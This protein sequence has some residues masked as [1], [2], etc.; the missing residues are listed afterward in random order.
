[1]RSRT[2]IR[3][4]FCV[5]GSTVPGSPLLPQ[6][7]PTG[8]MGKATAVACALDAGRKVHTAVYGQPGTVLLAS[9]NP[10]LVGELDA[11]AVALSIY[12]PRYFANHPSASPHHNL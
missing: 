8:V 4:G 10:S 6:D 5:V 7:R 3:D 9:R 11:G 2:P 12:C 1:M